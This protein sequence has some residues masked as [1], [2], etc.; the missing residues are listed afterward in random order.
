M[1]ARTPIH[2]D[3]TAGELSR[4]LAPLGA[5]ILLETLSRLDTLTPVPQ[6]DADATL[7]PRLRKADGAIDWR[8]PARELVNLARGCNPWP[9]AMTV[10]PGGAL[11][12]CRARAR[13]GAP[14]AAPGTLVELDG[15]LVVATG[16]GWL[17]PV[18]VR[19]E[20]RR[21]MGWDEYLR[22][23]RIAPGRRLGPP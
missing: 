10:A 14:A 12:I 21:I 20:N 19:P 11:T 9:G 17:L 8:R 23:A 6:R 5:E 2:P 22:G 15:T 3:E 16:E 1:S 4:R 13:D 7:A 18:E